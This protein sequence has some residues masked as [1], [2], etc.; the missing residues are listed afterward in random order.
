MLA[1]GVVSVLLEKWEQE[2]FRWIYDTAHA[3]VQ[4]ID[5]FESYRG[6][7]DQDAIAYGVN[8]ELARREIPIVLIQ[9]PEH[10]KR[11]LGFYHLRNK[12]VMVPLDFLNDT[13]KGPSGMKRQ[14]IL[15]HELAHYLQHKKSGFATI[16][17]KRSYLE[18]PTEMLAHV[19]GM[20]GDS[21][22]WNATKA[23]IGK[24]ADRK[25]LNRWLSTHARY[26]KD[27]EAEANRDRS[28]SALSTATR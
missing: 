20:A 19:M 11:S 2:D 16:R 15:A 7:M 4:I 27:I 24:T 1:E 3:A 10:K 23:V 6:L 9:W 8:K 13:P 28:G 17:D 22:R 18:K 14:S 25:T 12:L 26:S 21:S 5:S